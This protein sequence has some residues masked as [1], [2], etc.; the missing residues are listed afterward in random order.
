[1]AQ[2]LIVEDDQP[3]AEALA[4]TLRLEGHDIL[5]AFTAYEGIELG[6]AHC[7]D[8]VI[9]DW[10]LKHHLHGGDVCGWIR[11]ACPRVKTIVITGYPDLVPR[12]DR[13]S[14]CTEAIIDKP[15]HKERI[16]E[17]V[18]RALSRTTGSAPNIVT[19]E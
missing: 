7:P 9:A 11:A 8:L 12:A 17:A 3:F 10:M 16:L 19:N 1:M 14:A 5:V 2:I 6:L 15:F 18:S 13:W 4:S